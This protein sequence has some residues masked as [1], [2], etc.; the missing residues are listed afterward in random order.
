MVLN[1]YLVGRYKIEILFNVYT[2]RTQIFNIEKN[3]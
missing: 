1:V 2:P 3:M